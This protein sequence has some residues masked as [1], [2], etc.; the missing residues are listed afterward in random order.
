MF[1]SGLALRNFVFKSIFRSNGVDCY[2]LYLNQLNVY[3]I[4]LVFLLGKP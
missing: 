3:C 1:G 4:A 2:K